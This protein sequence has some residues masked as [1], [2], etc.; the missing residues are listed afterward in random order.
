MRALEG[1]FSSGSYDLHP[2]LGIAGADMSYQL[3]LAAKTNATYGVLVEQVAAGSPAAAAK[4]RAGSST[5]VIGGA[6]YLVGGDVIIS[7]NGIKVL[8]Q[9]GLAAYLEENATAGQRVQLGLIRSGAPTTV[10]VTLGSLP[11]S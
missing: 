8:N 5:V 3:A 4:I 11:G 7:V 9:D 1:L 2:Y 6:T 10:T